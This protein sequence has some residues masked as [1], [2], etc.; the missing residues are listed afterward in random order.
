MSD[1][2]WLH[3]LKRESR[4]IKMISTAVETPWEGILCINMNGVHGKY[5]TIAINHIANL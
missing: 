2:Y 4:L 3:R 5:L 1:E